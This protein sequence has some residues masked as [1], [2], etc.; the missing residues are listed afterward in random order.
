[1]ETL[2]YNQQSY[3]DDVALPRWAGDPEEL[4]RILSKIGDV[5][6]HVFGEYNLKLNLAKGKTEVSF[7][8]HTR[9][10]EIQAGFVATGQ[11]CNRDHPAMRL[12]ESDSIAVVRHYK[13][14]GCLASPSGDVQPE[15]VARRESTREG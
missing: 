4:V 13:Y 5:C 2:E 11:A 7:H 8:F 15:V 1:M 9:S 6:C 10:T 3:S 12:I 14:V